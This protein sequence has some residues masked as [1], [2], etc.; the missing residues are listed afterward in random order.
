M[1]LHMRLSLALSCT[2]ETLTRKPT[3]CKLHLLLL[4]KIELIP[5]RTVSAFHKE[6][7]EAC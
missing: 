3:V 5:M 7:E 6:E 4:E 1:R 2:E